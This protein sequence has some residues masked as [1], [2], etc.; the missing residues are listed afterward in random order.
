V[1]QPNLISG[2]GWHAIDQA[3][4]RRGQSSGRPRVKF[5]DQAKM[6]EIASKGYTHA[7]S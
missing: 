5:T 7:R 3:E 1:R 2:D 4:R 6:A